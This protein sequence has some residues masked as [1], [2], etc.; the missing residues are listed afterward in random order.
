LAADIWNVRQP[1]QV[2]KYAGTIFN[3]ESESSAYYRALRRDIVEKLLEVTRFWVVQIGFYESE[4]KN[5]LVEQRAKLSCE[6]A[7]AHLAKDSST[8]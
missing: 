3:I 6:R 2:W 8:L 4:D 5:R 1:Y 7:D